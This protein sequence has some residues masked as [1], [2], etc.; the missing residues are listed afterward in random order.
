MKSIIVTYKAIKIEIIDKYDERR[1]LFLKNRCEIDVV[2][3]TAAPDAKAA[4]SAAA[5][6]LYRRRRT[7]LALLNYFA[8]RQCAMR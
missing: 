7:T 4:A 6:V 2:N 5:L 3:V 8:L 1:F